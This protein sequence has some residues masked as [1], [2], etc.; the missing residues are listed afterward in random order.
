M[1]QKLYFYENFDIDVNG[2]SLPLIIWGLYIGIMLGVLGSII[3]RMYSNKIISA[4]TKHGACDESSA[5]TLAEL[6]LKKQFFILK[7]LRDDSALRRSVTVT[8]EGAYKAKASGKLADFWYGKFLRDDAPEKLDFDAAKF[9]LPEEKRV[10]A[11]LRFQLEG[12]PIRSFIIAAVGLF[13][14]AVFANFAVPELLQMLDN[15][16]SSVKPES[17]IL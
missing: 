9:Y 3:V 5:R 1:E 13:A 8:G 6:G 4:L 7:M 12:H 15:F 17:N 16:I 10:G 2:S 14:V 11:E